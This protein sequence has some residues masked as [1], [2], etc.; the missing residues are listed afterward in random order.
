MLSVGWFG[1]KRKIHRSYAAVKDYDPMAVSKQGPR[2]FKASFIT[3][4]CNKLLRE[5]AS[6]NARHPL[7]QPL[8]LVRGESWPDHHAS[9][10]G[11]HPR[12]SRSPRRARTFAFAILLNAHELY[13]FSIQISR[14]SRLSTAI[15][16]VFCFFFFI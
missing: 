16:S 14:P 4:D 15:S 11:D 13:D 12:A 10:G 1:V 5:N 2:I 8:R 7:A 9:D 6:N 3:V